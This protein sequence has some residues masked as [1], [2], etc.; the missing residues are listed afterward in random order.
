MR[1]KWRV[2]TAK[3]DAVWRAVHWG[4][5]EFQQVKKVLLA[6]LV[7]GGV[8]GLAPQPGANRPFLSQA[9][10]CAHSRFTDEG[11]MSSAWARVICA[12]ARK[13]RSVRNAYVK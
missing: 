13:I 3:R 12:P 9:Q 8:H 2:N 11:L 1:L 10:A 6:A 4:W 7:V 5:R